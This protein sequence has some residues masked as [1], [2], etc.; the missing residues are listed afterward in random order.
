MSNL[1]DDILTWVDI[2]DVISPYVDLKKSWSNY[3]WLSPFQ[4][5]NTPSFMVSP[6]KQIF[7]DFSSWIW[8][9]AITFIMEIEK[10]EF[11]D[12][13]K[14]LAPKANISL[15]DYLKNNNFWDSWTKEKEKIKLI[16]KRALE[17][18]KNSLNNC[19]S[20]MDYLIDNRKLDDKTI[21]KFNIWYATNSYYEILDY[22]RSK[23]FSNDD[24]ILSSLA[25]K[26]TYWDLYSFF[27]N[28]IIF[29]IYDHMDNLVAFAWRV[30]DPNDNPKYLNISETKIYDKS[31]I[32]YAYN[33]AKRNYKEFWKIIVVEWYMDV[34]W[35]D[36]AWFPIWV[37]PC[38]TSLTN[39]HIKLI[40][41]L[42]DNV[43]FSFDTDDA[44]INATIRWVKIAWSNDLFPKI[45]V[46]PDWYKDIDEYVN[47]FWELNYSETDAF[48]YIIE[49]VLNKYNPSSPSNRKTINN[50]VFD[51]FSYI[52]D[53]SILSY[54]MEIFA[55][56]IWVNYDII[57]SQFK[58]YL[59]NKR[60]YNNTRK[61]ESKN[62]NTE[63]KIDTLLS[64]FYKDFVNNYLDQDLINAYINYFDYIFELLEYDNKVYDIIRWN[65]SSDKKDI[66]LQWQLWR[67]K[68]FDEL[69][70]EK[71]SNIILNFLKSEAHRLSKDILQSKL[72]SNDKK[73]KVLETLKSL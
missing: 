61:E 54:Y 41:R 15:D 36:R 23:W 9:N 14:I 27:R 33:L 4:N 53:Y 46:L 35:L 51:M 28:R 38:W 29:P 44:W 22:L 73:Q 50:L 70:L 24:I 1:V 71:K 72:F 12:A 8:W 7:K 55:K 43:L 62:N 3:S 68:Q 40:K 37:A 69:K 19:Q 6:Q 17:F 42:T 64:L 5:E 26:S 10:C 66:L 65:I 60:T 49:L 13:V 57:F 2:V 59:K 67:E 31:K 47:E 45:L 48:E 18:F 52:S 39:H 30:L 63:L 32:L 21:K 25:K 20:A 34:I 16:N 56:K 58:S 11:W